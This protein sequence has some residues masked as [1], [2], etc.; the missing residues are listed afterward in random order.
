MSSESHSCPALRKAEETDCVPEYR[1]R[2][3]RALRGAVITFLNRRTT[4]HIACRDHGSCPWRTYLR[5][6]GR[7]AAHVFQYPEILLKHYTALIAQL[8]D[9]VCVAEHVRPLMRV[10]EALKFQR[11]SLAPARVQA[12]PCTA[13]D[14]F[15]IECSTEVRGMKVSTRHFNG[16]AAR[17]YDPKR[18]QD[19]QE[20]LGRSLDGVPVWVLLRSACQSR[21]NQLGIP[22]YDEVVHVAKGRCRGGV[23]EDENA[24]EPRK[25]ATE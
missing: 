23:H 4:I 9:Q 5:G 10:P 2:A 14:P 11:D 8:H 3:L 17:M 7:Q 1:S 19:S 18:L 6:Q 13:R 24:I 16:V 25:R 20:K 22:A 21:I 15:Q 12:R